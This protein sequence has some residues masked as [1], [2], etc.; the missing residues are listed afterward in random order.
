MAD[1][2]TSNGRNKL[3]TITAA[4][5]IEP[6]EILG[7]NI[8]AGYGLCATD[9]E[10]G[11]ITGNNKK[12]GLY[13]NGNDFAFRVDNPAGGN[14]PMLSDY[15]GDFEGDYW[16]IYK[17]GDIN[18]VWW[19][20]GSITKLYLGGAQ[21]VDVRSTGWTYYFNVIASAG[22][23]F[24]GLDLSEYITGWQ[25]NKLYVTMEAA[26][27]TSCVAGD[28]G[29]VVTDDGT[30]IGVL[31]DYNNTTR[32]WTIC[33]YNFTQPAGASAFAIT[34][35][36]G[37]GTS[38]AAAPTRAPERQQNI[39]VINMPRLQLDGAGALTVYLTADGLS[40]GTALFAK[41]PSV[42]ISPD[43]A[44]VPTKSL[45]ADL[46]TLTLAAGGAQDNIDITVIGAV[47]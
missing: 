10:L 14:T 17:Q 6:V 40:T 44:T 19:F 20:G 13:K 23:T 2:I 32:V 31:C 5:K 15:I 18:N 43:T 33:A 7:T 26:G 37:A 35:G 1:S 36:T 41:T 9:I 46:K 28:K 24:D 38:V 27:Y 45:S 4:G 30:A 8:T 16:R 21:K 29:K 25:A 22:V 3:F 42:H 11:G 12:V 39:K 47:A 34:A